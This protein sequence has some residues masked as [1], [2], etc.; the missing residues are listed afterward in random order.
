MIV[1]FEIFRT[2]WPSVIMTDDDIVTW[3]SHLSTRA[4]DELDVV[5]R[6]KEFML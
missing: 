3:F 6:Y 4:C 5:S 2:H 1:F